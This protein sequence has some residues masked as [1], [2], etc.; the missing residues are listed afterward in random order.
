MD[1]LVTLTVVSGYPADELA[2]QLRQLCAAQGVAFS[3]LF[4]DNPPIGFAYPLVDIS[5]NDLSVPYKQF[6]AKGGDVTAKDV[7]K[8]LKG[9]SRGTA[10]HNNGFLIGGAILL[11]GLLLF[12]NK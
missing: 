11:M 12:K 2:E 4:V 10:Q 6:W 3:Y 9:L 5:P 1:L 8:A 7:E